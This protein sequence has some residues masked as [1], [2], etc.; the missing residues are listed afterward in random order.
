MK[1]IFLPRPLLIAAAGIALCGCLSL[2]PA[3]QTAR[4][5]VLSP[6]VGAPP[7]SSPPLA[8]GVGI[9]KVPDY[10]FK[11]TIAIRKSTNEVAYILADLWAEHVNIGFQRVLAA[12]LSTL[13]PANQIRLSEWR[14]SDV[15]VGVYVTLEQFDVD[16]HGQGVLIAWW[17]VTSPAG[18]KV[19]K[20][21]QFRSKLNGPAPQA[22]PQGA[23]AT[24]SSLIGQ[25][26]SEIARA[27][28]ESNAEK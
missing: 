14:T 12:N 21:A 22:D 18:D 9:V 8:I 11:D 24:L 19:L 10:L 17:R 23:T 7:A 13:V 27:I 4:Y 28:K 2:K 15:A 3:R 16:E 1:T 25:L 26:S 6:V 5:F 20:S